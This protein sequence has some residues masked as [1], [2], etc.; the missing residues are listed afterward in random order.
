MFDGRY[1]SVDDS[2]RPAYACADA[3][4]GAYLELDLGKDTVVGKVLVFNVLG[5]EAALV[6]AVLLLMGEGGNA[7]F[8]CP[9]ITHMRLLQVR[10]VPR[11]L[12]KPIGTFPS[13][14][15]EPVEVEEVEEETE[16]DG[17]A[18]PLLPERQEAPW[19]R[20]IY[21]G[22]FSSCIGAGTPEDMATVPAPCETMATG[23]TQQVAEEAVLEVAWPEEWRGAVL[24]DYE[25]YSGK[26]HSEYAGDAYLG[27]G[28]GAPGVRFIGMSE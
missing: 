16:V 15:S 12:P 9:F 20:W 23:E 24:G 19:W 22:L 2:G 11:N 27:F 1:D 26:G 10:T 8:V 13:L 3:V 7:V 4:L 21:E 28:V 14:P 5:Q 17:L 25:V 6:G 18:E